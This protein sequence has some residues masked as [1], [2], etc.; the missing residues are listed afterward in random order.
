V[1]KQ[2]KS[3]LDWGEDRANKD[4]FGATVGAEIGRKGA[5]LG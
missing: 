1:K 4:E 2:N 5:N 3:F